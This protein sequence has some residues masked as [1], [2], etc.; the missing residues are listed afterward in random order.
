MSAAWLSKGKWLL[1]VIVL[2]LSFGSALVVRE[3]DF[4][5]CNTDYGFGF[6]E[7][8]PFLL[9]LEWGLL[10]GLVWVYMRVTISRERL[11]IGI[12]LGAGLANALER[13]LYGCV[14]DFMTLPI[15][16]SQINT[17]DVLITGAILRLLFFT[18]RKAH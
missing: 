6:L 15:V 5:F 9:L 7:P 10:A 3:G 13:L 16:G 14:A 12:L 18:D 2:I 17:A 4:F 11:F 8:G 1:P